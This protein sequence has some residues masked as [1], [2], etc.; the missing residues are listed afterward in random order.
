VGKKRTIEGGAGGREGNAKWFKTGYIS[1]S[2]CVMDKSKT[3]QQ[4]K[5]G[6]VSPEKASGHGRRRYREIGPNSRN[7]PRSIGQFLGKKSQSNGND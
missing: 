6:E 4:R 3:K 2:T 7:H 5:S 1:G